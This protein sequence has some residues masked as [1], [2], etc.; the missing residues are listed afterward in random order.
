VQRIIPSYNG[1]FQRGAE[2]AS[3]LERKPKFS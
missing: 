3:G 2:N 1:M